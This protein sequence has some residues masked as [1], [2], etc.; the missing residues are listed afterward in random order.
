MSFRPY[1]ESTT[2]SFRRRE[3]LRHL[4]RSVG[5]ELGGG[6]QTSFFVETEPGKFRRNPQL[7]DVDVRDE[8]LLTLKVPSNMPAKV[9]PEGLS[10]TVLKQLIKI[11][12]VG[13]DEL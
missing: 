5:V 11:G 12:T 9:P 3:R 13:G 1:E 2:Y 4:L 8:Q 7:S 10:T 6:A